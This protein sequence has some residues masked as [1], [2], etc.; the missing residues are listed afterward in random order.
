MNSH[1]WGSLDDIWPV[2]IFQSMP[3]AAIWKASSNAVFAAFELLEARWDLNRLN[4][5]TN[6]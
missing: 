4:K 6:K 5:Q 2:T 1:L 3:Q